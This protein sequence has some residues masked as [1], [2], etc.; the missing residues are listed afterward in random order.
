MFQTTILI[1]LIAIRYQIITHYLLQSETVIYI[2]TILFH[3]VE[4]DISRSVNFLEPCSG[5]CTGN[6]ASVNYW[7][8][9]C[10]AQL[11]LN[12]INITQNK[13]SRNNY[14]YF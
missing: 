7:L 10:D 6:N 9:W 12:D 5:E 4:P 13:L 2:K 11:H 8:F 1:K 14:C 3:T